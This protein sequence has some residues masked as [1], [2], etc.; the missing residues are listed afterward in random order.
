MCTRLSFF[1]QANKYSFLGN[2]KKKGNNIRNV[3]FRFE[4]KLCAFFLS[5][6]GK[7][8]KQLLRK[9]LERRIYLMEE[10]K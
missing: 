6:L 7:W 10:N 2:E 1:S 4:M 5:V 8:Q 9:D 3:V